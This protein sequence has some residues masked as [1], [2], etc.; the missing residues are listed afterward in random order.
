MTIADFNPAADPNE[1]LPRLLWIV[2]LILA[3]E[4]SAIV[5]IPHPWFVIYQY[6]GIAVVFGLA[7]LFFGRHQLTGLGKEGIAIDWT[8]V[9]VHAACAILC[10]VIEALLFQFNSTASPLELRIGVSLWLI[11]IAGLVVTLV[12][13][14]LTFQAMYR[15]GRALGNAWAYALL[16]STLVVVWREVLRLSWDVPDSRLGQFLQTASFEQAKALLS[17]FYRYVIADPTSHILGTDRFLI[18]VTGTCSGVEG[19]SLISALMLVWFIFARKELRLIRALLLV[20]VGLTLMWSLNIL[21]L[22]ALICLGSAGYPNAAVNGFH[23]EAGWIA[24]TV[25]SLVFLLFAQR[26]SWLRKTETDIHDAAVVSTQPS[27]AYRNATTIYLAPFLASTAASVIGQLIF[28]DATWLYVFRFAAVGAAVWFFRNEYRKID[29]KFGALGICA[30]VAVAGLWLGAHY[31]VRGWD[32]FNPGTGHPSE[33][34]SL[35]PG[36]RA[37]WLGIRILTAL[38][39]VPIAEELAFRGFVARRLIAKNVESVEF[40]RLNGSSIAFSSIAFGVMHGQ[41]WLGGIIAGIVFA[42]VA[43]FRDR[44]GESVAAHAAANLSIAA[45]AIIRGDYTLW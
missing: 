3:I 19:L 25:V 23:A 13:T 24:F 15:I 8:Y 26:S 16:C 27:A 6:R 18:E 10:A 11:L 7:L 5:Q 35:P 1:G 17:I 31:A 4:N 12:R 2:P 41:M 38:T 21:R 34:D 22:V 44:L 37:A 30:G 14:F 43:R 32:I 39:I 33:M 29:W 40:S 36:Q 42:I 28:N 45:V 9:G 20:P